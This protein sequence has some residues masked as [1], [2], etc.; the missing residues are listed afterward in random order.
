M[1]IGYVSKAEMRIYHCWIYPEIKHRRINPKCSL[2]D[3]FED[4]SPSDLSREKTNVG[5]TTRKKINVGY[6][7]R[8]N[9]FLFLGHT[10]SNG[11]LPGQ[12]D[13]GYALSTHSLICVQNCKNFKFWSRICLLLGVLEFLW[14]L[15]TQIVCNKSSV[16]KM[17][18]LNLKKFIIF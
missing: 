4:K 10:V 18:Y 15:G 2:S 5:Y 11:T 14:V 13:F 3:I 1:L 6:I 16:E 7:R 9:A 17:L 8:Y 12:R